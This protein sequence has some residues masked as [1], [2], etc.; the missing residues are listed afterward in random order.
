[1]RHK[2]HI[3]FKMLLA[4]TL[5]GCML[6]SP[7]TASAVSNSSAVSIAQKYLGKK[8]PFNTGEYCKGFVK[9]VYKQAFGNGKIDIV[10]T[11][12]SSDNSRWNQ[13]KYTKEVAHCNT[14]TSMAI[15]SAYIKNFL[16]K[17]K[18]GDAIQMDMYYTTIVN[19]K[20]VMKVT[21]H[22]MI[23]ISYSN[24]NLRVIDSNWSTNNDN[25]VRDHT[26]TL[27]SLINTLTYNMKV[28]GKGMTAYRYISAD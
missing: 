25:I 4:L 21:P 28:I 19:K 15:T 26:F 24:G 11:T 1:M 9:G 23:F 3:F 16:A 12:N 13:T 22:T 7:A 10:G 18:T 8:S 20:S 27:S 2:H 14:S 5:V 17:L 6:L